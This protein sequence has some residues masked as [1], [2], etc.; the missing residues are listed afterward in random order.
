MTNNTQLPAEVIKKIEKDSQDYAAVYPFPGS[1]MGYKYAATEYATK[2]LQEQQEIEQL[3]QWKAE[4]SALLNPILDYGKSKEAGIPLG[5][6]ITSVV[7]ERCKQ[8]DTAR[9]LLESV[10]PL[11]PGTSPIH[12]NIQTFLDGTR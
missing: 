2:Q 6:S 12:D 4:A 10:L 11:L 5:E 9:T 3:K 8:Y 1:L 7:L